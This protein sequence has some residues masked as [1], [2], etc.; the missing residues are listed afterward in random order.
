VAGDARRTRV[1][2]NNVGHEARL[3]RPLRPSTPAPFAQTVNGRPN[4]RGRFTV[5]GIIDDGGS[6]AS[7]PVSV[8]NALVL[9]L[10]R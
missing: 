10:V 8:T 5:Q 7:V 4:L 1:I 6:A 3:G 9:D 2:F